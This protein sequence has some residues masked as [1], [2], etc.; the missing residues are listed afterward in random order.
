MNSFRPELTCLEGRETP[1]QYAVYFSGTPTSDTAAQISGPLFL[2]AAYP[3]LPGFRTLVD[4]ASPAE[5]VRKGLFGRIGVRYQ[6]FAGFYDYGMDNTSTNAGDKKPFLITQTSGD[7]TGGGFDVKLEDL[8]GAGPTHPQPD[9]DYNDKIWPVYAQQYDAPPPPGTVGQ[10]VPITEPKLEVLDP[11]DA[12]KTDL[13]VGKWENAFNPNANND[14]IVLKPNF[15]DLDPDRY[16]LRVTDPKGKD[17]NGVEFALNGTVDTVTVLVSSLSDGGNQ[18]TLTETG[19]NTGVFE[20]GTNT[21]VFVTKYLLLVSN[22]VDD[23]YKVDNINDNTLDDRTL[24]VKVNDIVAL[25]YNRP[26][27]AAVNKGVPVQWVKTVNVHVTVMTSKKVGDA[28]ASNSEADGYATRNEV[29]EWMNKA[30]EQYA[31][32]GVR[33]LWTIHFADQPIGVDLS[34]NGLSECPGNATTITQE[35]KDLI[36]GNYANGNPLRTASMN[37]VDLFIINKMSDDNRGEA[38][39][40]EWL[41]GNAGVIDL[42]DTVIISWERKTPFTIPHEIGHVLLNWGSP[43]HYE[44]RFPAADAGAAYSNLMRGGTSEQ[45]TVI[46]TKRLRANQQT[47]AYGRRPNLI[48]EYIP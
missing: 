22:Q 28:G 19:A 5:A 31:Q 41:R 47:D 39:A 30:N 13:K 38:F 24:T 14:G 26:G 37:D 7:L 6:N 25:S 21:G 12:G 11:N 4:A 10:G 15:I 18:V 32:I 42:V 9:W 43:P 33:L 16:K 29:D 3:S 44:D 34:G 20:T 17:A 36:K 1:A 2:N 35:E 46:A 40:E 8:A 27:S 23:A 48:E 45:D